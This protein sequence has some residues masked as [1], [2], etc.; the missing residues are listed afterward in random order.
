MAIIRPPSQHRSLKR[1]ILQLGVSLTNSHLSPLA[2]LKST[3][4]GEVYAGLVRSAASVAALTFSLASSETQRVPLAPSDHQRNKRDRVIRLTGQPAGDS[5]ESKH[6]PGMANISP[7]CLHGNIWPSQART[8]SVC[9]TDRAI[10]QAQ[11]ADTRHGLM[12]WGTLEL[13]TNGSL[14][15]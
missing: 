9:L 12:K 6:R 14:R 10:N 2:F 4:H 1:S 3:T 11:I 8:A 13:M 15:Y 7:L 5:V